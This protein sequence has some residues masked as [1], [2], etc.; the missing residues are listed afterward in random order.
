MV[1]V[2]TERGETNTRIRQPTDDHDP[3]KLGV[4][5]ALIGGFVYL[6]KWN[7]KFIFNE[8]LWAAS[9]LCFVIVMT[10]GQTWTYIKR[11]PYA[12]RDP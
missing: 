1:A 6:W 7:R 3:F 8:N 5:L 12:Q 9:A 10:S 4:F 11:A 2:R